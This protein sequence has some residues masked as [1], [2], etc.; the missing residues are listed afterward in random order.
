MLRIEFERLLGPA[1]LNEAEQA[2]EDDNRENDDGVDQRLSISLVKP[3]AS[4][5]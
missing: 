2:V 1:F 5:T 3:A 4:R